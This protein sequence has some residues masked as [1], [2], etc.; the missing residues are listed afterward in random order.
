MWMKQRR[1]MLE[2]KDKELE[3]ERNAR[4]AMANLTK[5]V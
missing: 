3:I 4:G 1:I 5:L 2:T